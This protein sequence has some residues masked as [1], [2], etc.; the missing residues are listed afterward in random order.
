[1]KNDNERTPVDTGR[2][3]GRSTEDRGLVERLLH[4]AGP[5]PVVPTDG[6]E[7]V[8]KLIRPQWRE[9]ASVHARQRRLLWAGG[10]AVAA[11][12]IVA[13]VYLPSLRS[14]TQPP[15][16][17]GIV[18]ALL[19]GAVE[20][21]PPG[22]RARILDPADTGTEIPR[23]SLLRTLPGG[24]VAL[25]LT[26]TRSLRLDVNT[27]VR[28]DSEASISLDSGAVYISSIGEAGAGIEV[29]TA[30]GTASDIGTHFEVRLA[31]DTLDVKVREGLVS[32]AR[33]DE[34]Y[35]ITEGIVLS[36]GSDGGVSTASITAFD[37]AWE[38]TQEIAPPFEIEGRTVLAYL[39]WVSLETGFTIR[40][41]DRE[42]ERLVA[43]TILH[44]TIEGLP[45]A[46][47]PAAILPSCR[48]AVTE[49]PGSLLVRRMDFDEETE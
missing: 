37:P 12:V 13:A 48:L 31:P 14:V 26:E 16:Q 5:G 34:E 2:M 33:G 29:R 47:S 6:A 7:R 41:A 1:M 8:K 49:E 19:D 44:G 28:L 35:R 24:R 22:S 9:E 30:F 27:E 17:G 25:R 3:G 20:V 36:V 10:L 42:V 4:A 45:P 23:G 39:D 11:A 15:T 38:W 32:L 43:T 18:L 46:Q 21:V 40:F